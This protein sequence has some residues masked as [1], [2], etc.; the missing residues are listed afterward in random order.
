MR[1][2]RD[3]AGL[4]LRIEDIRGHNAYAGLLEG[5]AYLSHRFRLIRSQSTARQR[6]NYVHGLEE[7]E[8]ALQTLPR[9][10]EVW[11]PRE[12]WS[13]KL[14]GETDV[15]RSQREVLWVYWRQEGGD[16]M[17]RL[18]QIVSGLSFARHRTFEEYAAD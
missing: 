10:T 16:P 15:R 18:A 4:R 6:G 8:R 13:A 14:I 3:A 11:A 9:D 7:L 1:E 12:E 2:L 5:S 17:L